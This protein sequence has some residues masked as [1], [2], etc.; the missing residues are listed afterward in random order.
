MGGRPSALSAEVADLGVA[1]ASRLTHTAAVRA[2]RLQ[3]G[4]AILGAWADAE[5]AG[6]AEET[7]PHLNSRSVSF[8]SQIWATFLLRHV[9]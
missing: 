3:N 2:G 1:G 7:N 9:L 6:A 5:S 4:R 8:T